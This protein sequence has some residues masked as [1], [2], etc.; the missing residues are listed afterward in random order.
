[1]LEEAAECQVVLK[2]TQTSLERLQEC[3]SGL[4][5]YELPELIVLHPAAVEARYAQWLVAQCS[6]SFG[7]GSGV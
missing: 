3:L 6:S 2:C 5:P 1:V 7:P 4:H